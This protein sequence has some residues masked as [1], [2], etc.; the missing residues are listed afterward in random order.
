MVS[1]RQAAKRTRRQAR[2]G[3]T[4]PSQAAERLGWKPVEEWDD[5]ELAHG[6]PRNAAGNFSSPK[7]EWIG[8]LIDEEVQRRFR[9]TLRGKANVVSISAVAVLEKLML[10]EGFSEDDRG[11]IWH[12]VAPGV[13]ADIAKYLMDHVIGRPTQ[14][15]DVNANVKLVGML[16]NVV[17][18]GGEGDGEPAVGFA[19]RI[20][21]QPEAGEEPD[22]DAM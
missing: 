16:A 3:E 13:R 4:D 17:T 7:P 21:F 9:E 20:D 8:P 18:Q 22:E 19:E 5:L 14:P 1:P 11:R 2:T 6:R 15:V 10:D 12:K